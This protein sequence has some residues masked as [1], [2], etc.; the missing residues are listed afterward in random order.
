M[1]NK[2]IEYRQYKTKQYHKSRRDKPI[3]GKTTQDKTMPMQQATTIHGTPR[4]NITRRDNQN[5]TIP[6]H[7]KAMQQ[8]NNTIQ[9]K[10]TLTQD[11]TRQCNSK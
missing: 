9:Q 3:Q 11:K 4:Q 5:N 10:D 8:P 2:T 7:G 6:I 1:K